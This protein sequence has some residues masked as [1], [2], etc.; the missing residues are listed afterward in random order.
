MM[1][2][3]GSNL[4]GELAVGDSQNAVPLFP[5]FFLFFFFSLS[6]P[7][8]LSTAKADAKKDRAVPGAFPMMERPKNSH[9]PVV[10][11]LAAEH[12]ATHAPAI[13]V[14]L[15]P[16]PVVAQDLRVEVVRLVRRVVHVEFGSYP[17]R[18][19]ATLRGDV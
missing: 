18:V 3:A 7:F 4:E 5:F 16:Q 6:S 1:K 15:L 11:N 9:S 10:E 13:L 8:Y 2:P 17:S 19:S 12:V 14:P